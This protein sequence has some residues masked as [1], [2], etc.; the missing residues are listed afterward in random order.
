MVGGSSAHTQAGLET[1]P[2][3]PAPTPQGPALQH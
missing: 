3:S 1:E 2:Q